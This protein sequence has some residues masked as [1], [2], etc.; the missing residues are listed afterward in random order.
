VRPRKAA[1][2]REFQFQQRCCR[3]HPARPSSAY[4]SVAARRECSRRRPL[5]C[6]IPRRWW[7][8]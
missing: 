8:R 2:V 3:A 7:I 5:S 4:P 1:L 6:F